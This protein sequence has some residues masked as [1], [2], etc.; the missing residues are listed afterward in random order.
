MPAILVATYTPAAARPGPDWLAV[1]LL[2]FNT[3]A[4]CVVST[5]FS[6]SRRRH[7]ESCLCTLALAEGEKGLLAGGRGGGGRGGGG[8]D[9]ETELILT[10][11]K[12]DVVLSRFFPAIQFRLWFFK[13]EMNSLLLSALPQAIAGPP[14]TLYTLISLLPICYPQHVRVRRFSLNGNVEGFVSRMGI[15]RISVNQSKHR[16]AFCVC[17][18]PSLLCPRKRARTLR[19]W[20][21]KRRGATGWCQ[22]ICH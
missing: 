8:G 6:L 2:T 11:T 14:F 20:R 7:P 5:S 4:L 1:S 16:P 17:H 18:P 15:I 13:L 3:G 10:S 12:P 22:S 9:M 21:G 19:R